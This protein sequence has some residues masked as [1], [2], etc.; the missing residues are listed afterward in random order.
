[1]RNI[2]WAR[3]CSRGKMLQPTRCVENSCSPSPPSREISTQPI[4]WERHIWREKCW[5]RI[6][7]GAWNCWGLAAG[8]NLAAAQYTLGKL[9][10]EG[11]V[12][13]KNIL[14]ALDLLTKAAVQGNPFAQYRLGKLYL[15]GEDIPKDIHAAL[16]WLTKAAEQGNPYA[17][18]Q[19]G[20]LYLY[21]IEVDRNAEKPSP[22]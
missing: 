15:T 16:Y 20:R 10:A 13:P 2:C 12:V 6:S 3:R 9:Y 14:A 1:M 22:S 19:L 18:Y 5:R 21:G 4:P 11:T 7:P 17:G 8:Q